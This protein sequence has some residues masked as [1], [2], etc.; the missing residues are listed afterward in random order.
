MVNTALSAGPEGAAAAKAIVEEAS[1]ATTAATTRSSA[2]LAG[3]RAI[4]LI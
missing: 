1:I 4:F 2:G 3:K